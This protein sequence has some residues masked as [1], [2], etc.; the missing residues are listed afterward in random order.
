VNQNDQPPLGEAQEPE[1]LTRRRS[2]VVLFLEATI[3]RPPQMWTG[4]CE[5]PVRVNGFDGR[6]G[7]PTPVWSAVVGSESRFRRWHIDLEQQ[8]SAADPVPAIIAVEAMRLS[9][10]GDSVYLLAVHVRMKAVTDH[11]DEGLSYIDSRIQ[12]IPAIVGASVELHQDWGW[13]QHLARS[14]VVAE[15]VCVPDDSSFLPMANF[16]FS[17][18]RCPPGHLEMFCLVNEDPLVSAELVE[19]ASSRVLQIPGGEVMVG[20]NRSVVAAD[21]GEEAYAR[22]CVVDAFYF[23][24]A[25]RVSLRRLTEQGVFL[26]DPGRHPRA[27]ANLS[28]AIV[29]YLSLYSWAHTSPPSP[30]TRILLRYREMTAAEA[31]EGQLQGFSAA[32][33]TEVN[34]ETNLLLALLTILGFAVAVAATVSAGA[35]WQGLQ[36]LWGAGVA[37]LI[38]A[39]FLL[40]PFGRPI[41][42]ALTPRRRPRY[43]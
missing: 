38:F 29:G 36:I 18:L 12:E 23:V 27:A 15:L 13:G 40:L 4:W 10:A 1:W 43:R 6:A 37:L 21:F 16:G 14:A 19:A 31:L 34:G 24:L 35:K 7:L 3:L 32:A 11:D 22:T 28:R 41:R 5:G 42:Q 20:I 39:V 25:Q 8:V 33:Q 26:S 9:G 17:N 2:V 30:I